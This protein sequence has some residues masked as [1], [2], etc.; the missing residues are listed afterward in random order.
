[1]SYPFAEPAF[2]A[3]IGGAGSAALTDHQGSRRNRMQFR[4][5]TGA[6]PDGTPIE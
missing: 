3:E 4:V 5:V 2:E 6:P 1:M